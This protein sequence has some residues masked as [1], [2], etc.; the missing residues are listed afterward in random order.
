MKSLKPDPIAEKLRELAL[1]T[2]EDSEDSSV[3]IV[4]QPGSIVHVHS[5]HDDDEALAKI[6]KLPKW[7][8]PAAKIAGILGGLYLVLKAAYEAIKP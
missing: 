4:A 6:V 8:K 7:A 2:D 1:Y 5:E 3:H